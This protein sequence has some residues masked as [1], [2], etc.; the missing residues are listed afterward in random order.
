MKILKIVQDECPED[1][2]EWSNLG[3]MVC[4]HRHYRLGDKHS[5]ASPSDFLDWVKEQ[6]GVKNV[7]IE[8]LRENPLPSGGGMKAAFCLRG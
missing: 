8:Q 4:W 1:P 7:L 5:F 2:R 6:G 3:H